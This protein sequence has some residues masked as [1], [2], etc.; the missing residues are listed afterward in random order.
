MSISSVSKSVQKTGKESIFC[1]GFFS[2]VHKGLSH[3]AQTLNGKMDNAKDG[4]ERDQNPTDMSKPSKEEQLYK[5]KTYRE[6][7]E[8]L[9]ELKRENFNLKL[10][11]YFL[12]NPHVE[13]SNS[14]LIEQLRTESEVLK[15]QL[16]QKNYTSIDRA[17]QADQEY[18]RSSYKKIGFSMK[19]LQNT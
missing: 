13:Q 2:H 18:L 14:E 9:T 1:W 15:Q 8:E 17:R 5:L 7:D 10:R 4:D 11:I 19:N 3:S 12:E 6:F 16:N